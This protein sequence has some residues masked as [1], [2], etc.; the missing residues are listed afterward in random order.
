MAEGLV[1]MNRIESQALEHSHLEDEVDP[2]KSDE[3][4]EEEDNDARVESQDVAKR[5]QGKAFPTELL[6]SGIVDGQLLYQG[7]KQ[8]ELWR[9]PFLSSHVS[10]IE[11]EVEL[12]EPLLSVPMKALHSPLQLNT[13]IELAAFLAQRHPKMDVAIIVGNSALAR[14]A[15]EARPEDD[16]ENPDAPNGIEPDGYADVDA[17]EPELATKAVEN[18]AYERCLPRHSSQLPVC[19]VVPVRPN[20]EQHSDDVVPKVR[21][22]EEESRSTS[23]DDTHQGDY[24]GMN[25]QP[26]EEERPQVAR[27][28]SDVEFEVALYVTR[29]H[30][31]KDTLLQ[32]EFHSTFSR[33]AIAQ[34]SWL[35]SFGLTKTFIR[36]RFL[37]RTQDDGSPGSLSG[38]GSN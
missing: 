8:L 16:E 27:G 12:L 30:G 4:G 22:S 36:I 13:C 5:H 3:H 26:T 1:A 19:T 38:W 10:H 20:E 29:L 18:P 11:E 17:D 6:T 14:M 37:R 7:T 15:I 32:I 28:A 25:M 21:G 24:N 33:L 9:L 2:R 35:W 23:D 31:R 34:A